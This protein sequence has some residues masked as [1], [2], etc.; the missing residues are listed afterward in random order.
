MVRLKHRYIL[1][2]I[3]YPDPSTWPPA[4]SRTNKNPQSKSKSQAQLQIHSPTSD[5]LTPGLL[6]K[7][8]REE[9]SLMFGD[10]GVGRLGGAGAGGISVK[11]LSPATSTAIIRCPRASFRLVWTALTCMS[12]V[13]GFSEGGSKRTTRACV[14]RVIR[15]SGTMRKAEEEAIR[16]ARREIVRLREAEESGVLEG[17]LGGLVDVAGEESTPVTGEDVVGDVMM[18]SEDDE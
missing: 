18:E 1:L 9:V 11:Y 8:V 16:R 5:A 4:T 15:V 2:D 17:L 13:P 7:M 6:A 12:Q 14:F 10:Y 3:L